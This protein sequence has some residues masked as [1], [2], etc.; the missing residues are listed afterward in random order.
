MQSPYLADP[1]RSG[2]VIPDRRVRSPRRGYCKGAGSALS[3]GYR[4]TSPSTGCLRLDCSAVQLPRW[5]ARSERVAQ[6]V[7]DGSVT[8]KDTAEEAPL[9]INSSTFAPES[10]VGRYP[11]SPRLDS[12]ANIPLPRVPT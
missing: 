8:D 9:G 10:S 3:A 11:T 2:S 6:S 12:R 4:T 7:A 1:Y 5:A